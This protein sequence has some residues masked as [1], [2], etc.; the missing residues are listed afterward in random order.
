V[1]KKSLMKMT[2]ICWITPLRNWDIGWI[3]LYRLLLAYPPAAADAAGGHQMGSPNWVW[4][5]IIAHSI[6]AIHQASAI[7][8]LGFY[9]APLL[10][11]PPLAPALPLMLHHCHLPLH[12]RPSALKFYFRAIAFPAYPS[13]VL[14]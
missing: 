2:D 7:A 8:S 13:S 10:L 1:A 4:P 11:E 5:L 3:T 6:L 9:I 12:H 14:T